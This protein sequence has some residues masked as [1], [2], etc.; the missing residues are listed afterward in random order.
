[1]T[2][3]AGGILDA[4]L[5]GHDDGYE[6]ADAGLKPADGTWMPADVGMPTDMRAPARASNSP[7][8]PS[9]PVITRAGG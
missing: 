1:M 5:R 3:G 8:P 7:C 4:R 9:T 2:A 6:G